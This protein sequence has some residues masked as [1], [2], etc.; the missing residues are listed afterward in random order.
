MLAGQ[1][2]IAIAD[3]ASIGRPGKLC[4]SAIL[5]RRKLTRTALP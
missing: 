5:S 2:Y 1:F 3:A 4:L